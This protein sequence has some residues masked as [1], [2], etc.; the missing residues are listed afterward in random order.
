MVKYLPLLNWDIGFPQRKRVAIS[1]NGVPVAYDF[2][3]SWN[4]TEDTFLTCTIT[5]VVD[6]SVMWIGVI[7]KLN[8][9]EVKDPITHA[10]QFTLMARELDK[11]LEL[12]KI[13]LFEES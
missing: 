12:L 1:T 5:R 11:S 10:I 7:N 6:S 9:F 13:W 3:Y 4:E 8:P 2:L